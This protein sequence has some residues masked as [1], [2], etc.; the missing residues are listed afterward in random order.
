LDKYSP[1]TPFNASN[2]VSF[3]Y[4]SIPVTQLTTIEW[5]AFVG[6]DE[7]EFSSDIEVIDLSEGIIL[8]FFFVVF[9]YVFLFIPF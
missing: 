2:P 4:F 6:L 9:L 8:E 7:Y 1:L 5:D 3:I